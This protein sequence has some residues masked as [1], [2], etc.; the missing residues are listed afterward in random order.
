MKPPIN[1]YAARW[2][3][4]L[5]ARH[6]RAELAQ[7]AI[8]LSYFRYCRAYGGHSGEADN[9]LAAFSFQ[10]LNDLEALFKTLGIPLTR[11][12]KDEP[13]PVFGVKYAGSDY[14][15]FRTGI[16]AYPDIMQP[17]FVKVGQTPCQVLVSQKQLDILVV[18][19]PNPYEVTPLTV[20][21]ALSAETLLAKVAEKIIDPPKDSH[22]CV[23]PK[24]YPELWQTPLAT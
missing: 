2:E 1:L 22:H 4:Y 5:Y 6:T 15:K 20:A 17:G 11:L 16:S 10:D 21:W 9:L 14:L 13:K 18:N 12:P 8:Q 3:A 7:W 19:E 23:C 24:Y